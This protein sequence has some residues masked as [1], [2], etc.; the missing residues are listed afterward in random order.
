[1]EL[2]FLTLYCVIILVSI[3]LSIVWAAIAFEYATFHAARLWLGGCG[4]ITA[5][6]L[7]LPFQHMTASMLPAVGGNGMIVAGFW[8][9]WLGAWRFHGRPGGWSLVVLATAA[10]V[11]AMVL[12]FGSGIALALVYAV[13]Q[14]LPMALSVVFLMSGGR[15]TVGSAITCGG[16]FIG[17]AGHGTVMLINL[18][19][20]SGRA[21]FTDFGQIAALTMLG[22]IFSGILWN[23]GFAVMTIDQLRGEVAVLAQVDALTG[24]WN[25]RKFE[26]QIAFEHAR[27]LRTARSYVLLLLDLDN[28]KQV[29]DRFGH[30]AGDRSLV[31]FATIAASRIRQTDLLARLGGDEFCIL[32]PETAA[33]EARLI[34]LDIASALAEHPFVHAGREVRLTCSIGVAEGTPGV[35]NPQATL[36]SADRALYQVKADGRDGV[37]VGSF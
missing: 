26:E 8:L 29:N 30:G 15:R 24:V 4:L 11:V 19:S 9:L 23:F 3:A 27:T 36:E 31:H 33:A 25:R 17:L 5:G 18:W 22:V 37:A 13:A 1:M 2:H 21:P 32:M 14:S 16:I 12:A 20:L 10:S 34:G 7:A 6:G 35:A 28:F